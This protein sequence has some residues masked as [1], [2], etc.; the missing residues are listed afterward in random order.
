MHGGVN[1]LVSLGTTG[2]TV[3]LSL[4]EKQEVLTFTKN[5]V[6]GRVPLVAGF[7]GNNTQYII[8]KINSFDI[9]G[10]E[11]I[12]S[13]SPN[14][15]K[16]TQ[17]GIYQHYK[18]IAEN[19]PLPII[20]YNVPG[21]T[22]QNMTA[23]TTVRLAHDFKNII[24]IKEAANDMLQSMEIMKNKPENFT[25]I[26]GDDI[27][28]LPMMSFGCQGVISVVAQAIP[29]HFTGMVNAALNH[30]WTS[31]AALQFEMN[32]L[33]KAIFK[34]NNPAG[35]KAALHYLGICQNELRLPLVPVSKGLEQEIIQSLT[36]LD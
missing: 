34:E 32:D 19:T 35:I 20:L 25:L 23:D 21:R 33:I 17:E 7:G 24:A 1:Y 18:A 9:S 8:D 4:E 3:A 30:H 28:A 5:Y 29:K 27:H 15:N 16:P 11:A 13:S 12:L 26:S 14:Y 22:A 31:A 6:N 2:E 36:N 10:Y